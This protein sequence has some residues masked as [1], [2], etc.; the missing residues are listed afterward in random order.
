MIPRVLI[1]QLL[2]IAAIG[3]VGVALIIQLNQLTAR[4]ERLE[5]VELCQQ[6]AAAV[7]TQTTGFSRTVP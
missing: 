5:R 7:G 1:A 3:V 2:T 6:P 4:L